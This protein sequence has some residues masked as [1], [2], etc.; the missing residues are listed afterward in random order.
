VKISL[1]AQIEELQ[2]AIDAYPQLVARGNRKGVVDYRILALQ[3]AKHTLEWVLA[4]E[5]GR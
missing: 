2:R 4:Q 3:A 5:R 1:D